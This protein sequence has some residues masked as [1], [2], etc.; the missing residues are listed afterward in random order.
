MNLI[1][2]LKKECVQ[3]GLAASDKDGV[4][5]E[6]AGLAMRSDLL[7]VHDEEQ[8]FRALAERE[9]V[10]ST[11]FG[12]GIA[13]PHCAL[14]DI[15]DFVV[16]LIA[17]PDGVDFDSSNGEPT[18]LITFIIGPKEKRNEHVTLLSAISR[19]LDNQ[20]AVEEL[21]RAGNAEALI[22]SFLRHHRGHIPH[23][24]R[25]RCIFHVVV[26][27]EGVFNEIIQ[28][29]SS[30]VEGDISVIEAHNAGHYLDRLPMFAAFWSE[31]ETGFCRII[32][33]VVDKALC[34]DVVRR[35]N[36]V[37]KDLGHK[38]GVLVT[39]QELMLVRGSLDF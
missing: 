17:A 8:V 39:V 33:A 36:V 11:A 29:F 14:E 18:K 34:N 2:C 4:L 31:H 32:L 24:D 21:L 13:I 28:I 22:E 5:K 37:V 26:Q 35:I 15:D 23:Q 12:G 16:G 9:A 38:S 1:E 3:V 7:K 19:V 25:E 20:D 27:N 6:I 10:G 30:A